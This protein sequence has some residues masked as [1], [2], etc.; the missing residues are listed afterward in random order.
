M[1][2]PVA[3]PLVSGRGSVVTCN[4][5]PFSTP[6]CSG[7]KGP[8]SESTQALHAELTGARGVARAGQEGT[9]EGT[10]H[11]VPDAGYGHRGLGGPK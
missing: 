4:H 9:A 7:D 1:V 6:A 2:G 10:G 5:V 11:G 3:P 8:E